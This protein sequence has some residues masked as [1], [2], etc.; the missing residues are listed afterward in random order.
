MALHSCNFHLAVL[1]GRAIA[2]CGR[3]VTGAG[4]ARSQVLQEPDKNDFSLQVTGVMTRDAGVYE[5]Q[6]NT[7]PKMSWPVTLHVLGEY[8]GRGPCRPPPGPP[9]PRTRLPRTAGRADR[10]RTPDQ[11]ATG[12]G[13]SSLSLYQRVFFRPCA[14]GGG[15]R[16]PVK[17]ECSFRCQM[18][19]GCIVYPIRFSIDT[20]IDMKT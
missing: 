19:V 1:A 14:A 17:T 4:P 13:W 2:P 10:P 16:G 8:T 5:C 11:T 3:R 6:V 15:T 12:G 7:E 20:S 18:S 9:D